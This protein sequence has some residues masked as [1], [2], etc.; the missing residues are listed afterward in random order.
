MAVR[1]DYIA[2]LYRDLLGRE[3]S[4][5]EISG[6]ENAPDEQSVANMFMGSPEYAARTGGQASWHNDDS[7]A[8]VSNTPPPSA[9]PPQGGPYQT[10]GGGNS[11]TLPING[12][13]SY[14]APATGPGSASDPNSSRIGDLYLKY[15]G[16]PGSAEELSKWL[17]GAFGWGDTNNL[18]GIERGISM[19]DEA[20]RNRSAHPE[21][22]I[23]PYTGFNTSGNDYSAF[24]TG[25]QQDPNKSAKDAFAYL[26]N[27]APAPPFGSK[28]QLASWF[29]T[30]IRPG[31]DAL[32]HKV[33][34][35]GDD[36]FTYTNGEG[37]FTVDYAQN[38]GAPTGSMLQRLQWGATPADDA[39]RARYATTGTASTTAPKTSSGS[40][41][42][43]GDLKQLYG[44]LGQ[45]YGGPGGPGITNGPLQQVGQDPLSFLITG[46]LADFIGR[47]GSTAF[48]QDVQSAL[49]EMINGKNPAINSRFE[50]ARELMSKGRRTQVN[51]ARAELANRGLLSEPGIPQGA[52]TGAIQRIEDNIAPEFARALR[53]IYT[54]E[55]G[56]ALQLA[57]GMAADQARTFLAGLGEGTARQTALAGIALQQLS[58]NMAW[59]Q[60]LA[61]FGLKRD[62]VLAQLQQGRTDDVMQLLNTF[63]S[64]TSLSRGGYV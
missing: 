62:Q 42:T 20:A 55:T 18:A 58:Q 44:Q 54:E 34:S 17:T 38:A 40:G 43:L 46:A 56:S 52:E 12:G 26:T 57:T 30:Y 3:G 21:T 32:G 14:D 28:S 35:V 8:I 6:W 60:F 15:L 51:D 63:L 48:G 39:T 33:I 36:S 9:P 10:Q 31:M 47:G 16:R 64:L 2:G 1:P 7:G 53:D 11:N 25:R 13:Y 19:S 23:A 59:S 45:Q 5:G 29:N 22:A 4:A 41:G 24:N 37:T 27:K 49:S 61:E 50:S